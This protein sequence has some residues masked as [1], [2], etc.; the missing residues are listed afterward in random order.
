MRKLESPQSPV[1]H[2][3]DAELGR[4]TVEHAEQSG[5]LTILPRYQSMDS[6]TVAA[7]ELNDLAAQISEMGRLELSDDQQALRARIRRQRGSVEQAL[8]LGE[9]MLR[10][11]LTSFEQDPALVRS[12]QAACRS[13]DGDVAFERQLVELARRFNFFHDQLALNPFFFGEA[14]QYG[15]TRR[16][17]AAFDRSVQSAPRSRLR[18]AWVFSGVCTPVFCHLQ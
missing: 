8:S 6:R 5:Y 17:F 18:V 11:R 12:R 7:L 3:L 13:L 16:A 9:A 2:L 15:Y 10:A 1:R 4:F 14:R